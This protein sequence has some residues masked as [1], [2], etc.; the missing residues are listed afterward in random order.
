MN[1]GLL[2][3]LA[4]LVAVGLFAP[5]DYYYNFASRILIAAIFA[6]S[7]NILLGQA[8]L[9]SLG[10]AAYHGLAAYALAWL[11]A[12][13]GWGHLAAVAAALA[14]TAVVAAGFGLLALR[15]QGTA[16]LM[17]T[18]ALGQIVWGLAQRWTAVTGGDNG[19]GGL[20]RPSPGGLDLEPASH[21]Y[22]F[23]AAVFFAACWFSIRLAHSPF[24][25]GL[26]GCRDQ[27][28]RMSAL[29]YNVF[30]LRWL[31]FVA[32]GLLAGVA[33]ILYA[34]HNKF[35]S[36]HTLSLAESATVLLMVIVGGS[37]SALGPALGA[38]IVLCF[39]QVASSYTEH[40]NAALG[41]LFLLVVFLLPA[42]IAPGLGEGWQRLRAGRRR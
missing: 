2:A 38:A 33:G 39:A 7:L 11:L 42:G 30:L 29:G 37:A 24:G 28:R 14:L 16:F 31:G 35:V 25:A 40:W 3:L 26:R 8:G 41:V 5:G 1:R 32:A 13:Q 21:F 15:A 10:H 17:I 4:L 20:T 6:L 27:A 19:I 12:S 36:P 22:L 18:L 34:Y 23:A 9:M